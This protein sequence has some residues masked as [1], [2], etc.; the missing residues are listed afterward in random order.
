MSFLI[1]GLKSTFPRDKLGQKWCIVALFRRV[2]SKHPYPGLM[3]SKSVLR[4]QLT[5]IATFLMSTNTRYFRNARDSRD[6][7]I[8]DTNIVRC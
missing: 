2:L 6:F 4:C 5:L 3:E 8:A 1:F 7:V